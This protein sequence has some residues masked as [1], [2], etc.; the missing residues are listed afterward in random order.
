MLFITLVLVLTLAATAPVQPIAMV[1]AIMRIASCLF[2]FSPP[3]HTS[4]TKYQ[5]FVSNVGLCILSNKN[6]S[7]TII[8]RNLDKWKLKGTKTNFLVNTLN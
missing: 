6:I 5:N 2:I 3:T 7:N 4:D 1:N 8:I